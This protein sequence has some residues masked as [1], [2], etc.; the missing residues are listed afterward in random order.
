[1]IIGPIWH[2]LRFFALFSR[3][4]H[5]IFLI[6]LIEGLVS[7]VEIKL[8]FWFFSKI[9]KWPFLVKIYRN[10]ALLGLMRGFSIFF[11]LFCYPNYLGWKKAFSP[12]ENP[13]DS[14]LSILNNIWKFFS[15]NIFII[16]YVEIFD[17]F[18]FSYFDQK[19]WPKRGQ[20]GPQLTQNKGF[21]NFVLKLLSNL[22]KI[23]SELLPWENSLKIG[24]YWD[25]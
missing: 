22:L 10:L 23:K 13:Y 20:F 12:F 7:G 15:W 16:A 14:P 6:F 18:P 8:C 4:S 24:P 1:M 3:I 9:K 21:I 19:F 5:N 25:F 2:K 11:I 17:F